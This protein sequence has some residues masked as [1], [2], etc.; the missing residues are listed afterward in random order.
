MHR[1]E[2]IP[3]GRDVA[4]Q[5]AHHVSD[6]VFPSRR[7]FVN[8]RLEPPK[9]RVAEFRELCVVSGEL[10]LD[11]RDPPGK[12]SARGSGVYPLDGFGAS[13]PRLK[14]RTQTFFVAERVGSVGFDHQRVPSV[15][16]VRVVRQVWMNGF[17]DVAKQLADRIRRESR[18][19]L[20]SGASGLSGPPSRPF[21]LEAP[22]DLTEL[23]PRDCSLEIIELLVEPAHVLPIADPKGVELRLHTRNVGAPL[24]ER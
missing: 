5:T 11:L 17:R 8:H 9:R 15:S 12:T 7:R 16:R 3:G 14:N 22:V 19:W 24:G 18:C 10:L 6:E 2:T 1:V 21:L 20:G 23:R 13:F 4:L